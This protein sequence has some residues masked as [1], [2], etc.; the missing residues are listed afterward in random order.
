MDAVNRLDRTAFVEA[1]G[2]IFEHSPWVAERAWEERPFR[3]ARALLESMVR[4]VEKASAE[5]Q[6]ALLR[7][8]PDLGT[9]AKLSEASAAEQAGAALD[10]LTAEEFELLMALNNGYKEKFGFPFL[11][12]VK[13]SD[14][15]DIL[16]ALAARIDGD[17][18]D[19]HWEAL[20][21]VYRIASFRLETCIREET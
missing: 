1:L 2:W 12:A 20:R 15:H 17:P 18:E 16:V 10:Q 7:A 4:Q 21:Q 11:Y 8:H 6:T 3:D 9:R 13:G 19:E 14:K 5:E